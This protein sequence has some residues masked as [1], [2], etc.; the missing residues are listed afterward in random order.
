MEMSRFGIGVDGC[1]GGWV[2]VVL[3][4]D[5]YA[6]GRVDS[7]DGL[8]AQIPHDGLVFIDMPIGL[9]HPGEIGRRCDREARSHLGVRR[10]SVFATPSRMALDATS[11]EEACTLNAKASGRKLSRQAYNILPKIREVDTYLQ[12][13]A[14]ARS[15]LRES[16]PELN[17]CG[18]AG[19]PMRHNKRTPAG[20][21]ERLAVLDRFSS[22]ACETMV[23]AHR[24]LH[25]RGVFRDDV[26][27]AFVNA[28]AAACP[29]SAHVRVPEADDMDER[30]LPRHIHS[31]RMVS[32]SCADRQ[33]HV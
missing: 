22:G 27:D 21:A 7:L 15:R 3:G 31:V 29:A 26:V 25:A 19:Q 28:L 30:S 11:Y 33:G 8:F 23:A 14:V 12:A 4:P 32:G 10:S 1:P 2:F 18:F 16:H 5:Y 6:H 9:A 20:F 17:F 24:Q 13:H